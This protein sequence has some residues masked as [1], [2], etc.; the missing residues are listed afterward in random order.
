MVLLSLEVAAEVV[1]A[2][3]GCCEVCIVDGKVGICLL[4]FSF[5]SPTSNLFEIWLRVI[6]IH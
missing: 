3:G 1:L 2:G 5:S 4:L 6:L